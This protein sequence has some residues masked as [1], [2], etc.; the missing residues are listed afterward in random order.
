MILN[1]K[2]R[3][4]IT[5]IL[6]VEGNFTTLVIKSDLVKKIAITQDEIKKYNIKSDNGLITWSVESEEETDFMFTDLELGL[7]RECLKK[8]DTESKLNDETLIIYKKFI[9]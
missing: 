2:E 7:I 1:L 4:I 8:L 3:L 6:P 9:N 5:N